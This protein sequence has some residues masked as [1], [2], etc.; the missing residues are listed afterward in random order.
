MFVHEFIIPLFS[1][2]F[3]TLGFVRCCLKF[4]QGL[5]ERLLTDEKA[6]MLFD[7]NYDGDYTFAFDNISDY[8]IIHRKL[9]IINKNNTKKKSVKFYVLVAFE[10]TDATDIENA[11]KRIELLFHYRCL[12]Y[13]MRYMDKDDTPWKRSKYRSMY[14]AIAR[15]CNQPSIVKKMTFREFCI[16]NQKSHKTVGGYC[17]AM[18]SMLEFEKEHPEIAEKYFDLRFGEKN[19]K[20]E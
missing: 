18:K 4:K 9:A 14:V 7:A 19:P 13:I 15:W 10:S 20:F 16:T 17:S 11:F 2:F 5:D 6:K 8:D 12:P 3:K 1:R